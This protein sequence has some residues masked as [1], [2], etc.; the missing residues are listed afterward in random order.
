MSGAPARHGGA[1]EGAARTSPL[2]ALAELRFR[3]TLRRLRGRSGVPEIV[4]RAVLLVMALPAGA[5][6][7]LLA[8]TGAFQAVRG[9]GMPPALAAAALFFGVWQTWTV[10]AVTLADRES[11]DLRRLL[12]YPVPPAHAFAYEMAASYLGDPFALF[13]SLLLL[14]AFVGAAAARPGP[15]ILLLALTHLLF[16]A[17]VVALVALLQE[18]LARLLRGRQA[19]VLGVAAVYV[20]LVALLAWGSSA[21]HRALLRS[22]AALSSARWV[23]Y[24]AALAAEAGAALYAGRA[25]R[26]IPWLAAQGVTAA[27]T[28]WCAYRL[29]LSDTRSG[30]EGGAARGASGGSGWRL[31]G[32]LGPILEKELKVL[33]RHPLVAVLILVVPAIAGVVGWRALP[34]IPAEAG[35]V[36][37]ALPLFG[38]ALYAQLVTQ[39]FW[40]NAFGWDRGGARL[41]FLV[42]LDPAEVLRA[43]NAA[44][45]LLSLAIFAASAAALFAA[46]GPPPA[47]A[48]AAALALHLGIGPWYRAAGNVVSILNPAPAVHSLQR[49][50]NLAP[51][52]SLAGLAIVSAGAA[53]FAP[54]VLLALRLDQPWLLVV[55]WAGL[56][57]VGAAVRRAVLPASARLLSRRREALLAAVAGDGT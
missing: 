11:F 23:A 43:K 24:P 40:L 41:W 17:G 4:A 18:V 49:G 39:A 5:A 15:W 56:G 45:S 51:A 44:T 57:L 34:F 10:V 42:P 55:A 7:A 14:G 3:L 46:G 20:G 22:L 37:R 27:A 35:E 33:L 32:R 47:W 2:R 8:G 19:R 25:M 36:V 1:G 53:L 28:A 31:P 38:F 30:V 52:S 26:A 9:R 29:A 16:A 6:F 48:M 54:P 12:V 50:G 13:W 21:G